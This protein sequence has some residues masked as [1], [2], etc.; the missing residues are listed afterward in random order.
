MIH[1]T[2]RLGCMKNGARDIKCHRWFND[3]DW[4]DVYNKKNIAPI[5]PVIKS[6]NDTSNFD[7][8]NEDF[9]P[10]EADASEYKMFEDF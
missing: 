10:E 1:R 3:V 6:L 7:D 2:K 4:N 5:Q 9:S 8:Y